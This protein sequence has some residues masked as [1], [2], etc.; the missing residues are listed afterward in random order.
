MSRR[1]VLILIVVCSLTGVLTVALQ[2]HTR[3]EM[4][5]VGISQRVVALVNSEREESAIQ[6]VSFTSVK[7]ARVNTSSPVAVKPVLLS[8]QEK[9]DK[10]A[11]ISHHPATIPTTAEMFE[12]L[13]V[14]TAT[15]NNHFHEIQG[16]LKSMHN[17]FP[18]KKIIL[19]DLGMSPDKS[20]KLSTF[21][22]NIELRHFPF[23]DYSHLPH[24]KRLHTYAWKPIIFKLVSQEYDVIMY[25]DAS[26]R[27]R[28]C[29]MDKALEHVI[30]EFPLLNA[31]P[32]Y[33]H[34]VE[35]T[36]DGMI[37]YLHF[38]KARKDIADIQTLEASGWLMWV[39]PIIT[40]KV[41]E[42]WL[43]CALHE[44]CIAPNGTRIWPCNFTGVHDGHFVG[45]H[46]FDQSAIN[47]IL[48]REFGMNVE[49]K[50]ADADISSRLWSILKEN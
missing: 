44:E 1:A 15:S 42:P 46:R 10:T 43:D 4:V 25:G 13:V 2:L 50:A 32:L 26:L 16:M 49:S 3:R 21:V 27:M 36:H 20:D 30:H 12:R 22:G 24:V 5:S 34:A 37:E 47:L 29:D 28:T 35:F 33:H 45:C 18:D 39:T 19:Y 31:R 7:P 14:L 40:E 38:P 8:K 11:P 23:D 48:V 17:C 9:G 41:I 6:S